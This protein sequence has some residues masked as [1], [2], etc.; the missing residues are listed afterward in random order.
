M[1]VELFEMF[2]LGKWKTLWDL[3]KRKCGNLLG[4]EGGVYVKLIQ[5]GGI[6]LRILQSS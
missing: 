4:M 1:K 5:F 6:D 3:L 2:I